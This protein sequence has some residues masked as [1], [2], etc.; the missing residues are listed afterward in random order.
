MDT[1]EADI[2]FLID[3]SSSLDYFDFVD[4][5]LF[6]KEVVKLFT[7]GPNKVRFGVVQ[8]SQISELEFGLEEYVKT[9]D[10][11]KAI[12]NI[13]QVGGS[14]HTGAALK[15]MQLLL[16]RAQDQHSRRVPCHL[17]VLTDRKSEDYVKEPA[18]KLRNEMVNIY[19]IG[20]RQANESQIYEIAESKD[21][22][23]FVNDF[24][25]LKHIK[26]EVV[27]DICAVDGKRNNKITVK[28]FE[29]GEIITTQ[30]NDNDGNKVKKEFAAL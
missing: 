17:I 6:L 4:L 15:F 28:P 2:Y 29:L 27:R 7:T 22:A 14:P 1:E 16:K 25:S 20:L 24:A 3:G 11:L 12:D 9:S 23:Y 18:R 21:R 5:K 8:Y 13:R 26:N 19:A 30:T 10:I